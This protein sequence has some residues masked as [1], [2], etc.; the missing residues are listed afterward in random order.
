M[1]KLDLPAFQRHLAALEFTPL[2]VDVLGWNSPPSSAA[3]W[4]DDEAASH[5][6]SSRAV[7]TLGGVV[8]MQVVAKQGWPNEAVRHSI[9]RHLSHQHAEN[10]LI[11]TE[12]KRTPS[13]SLWYWVKRGRD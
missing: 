1:A 12:Q 13:Q 2:F 6:F 10:L 8:V 11:F 7:A 3:A 9:W 4:A 5:P